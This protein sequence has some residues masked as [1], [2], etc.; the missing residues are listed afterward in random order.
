MKRILIVGLL[1]IFCSSLSIASTKKGYQTF[2]S[3]IF[4]GMKFRSIGPAFTSG[5]IADFAVNPAN[6]K[7]YYVGVASGNIWK[8]VNAGITWQ[9]VFDKYGSYSIGCLAMDPTNP[10]VVWA[11]TGE[12]N[13]QRSVSYGDGVYKTMDGGKNWKNMGL[14]NSRHI[15]KIV[16]DPK[17]PDTVYVAAEGSLWGPGGDRGLY[18]TTDGG[19][20]WKR[21]LYISEN[22]GINEILMDPRNPEVLYASSEQRRRHVHTKIGGGPETAIYKSTDSCKS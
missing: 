5:R 6:P 11:G 9:P 2:D 13:H 12:N 18:K 20:T 8:T 3:K 14:K 19:K 10:N 17:H 4:K 15:G 1:V 7:E 16:I 22:T 21:I